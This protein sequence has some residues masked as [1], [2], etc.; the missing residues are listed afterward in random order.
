MRVVELR[1]LK[2]KDSPIIYMREWSGV[3][4]LE[5]RGTEVSHPVRV[6]IEATPFG[7]PEIHVDFLDHPDWPVL[8]LLKSIKHLV[9]EMD[10]AGSLP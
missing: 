3:A 5:G 1:D 6:V 4:V 9:L 10:R 2:R 8:P 7:N